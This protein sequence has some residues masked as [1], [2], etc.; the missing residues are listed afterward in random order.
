MSFW[1]E[2]FNYKD[3]NNTDLDFKKNLKEELNEF[4]ERSFL[5]IYESLQKENPVKPFNYKLSIDFKR[6][7][8]DKYYSSEETINFSDDY[9][10]ITIS[11]DE[12]EDHNYGVFNS[13]MRNFLFSLKVIAEKITV[14]TQEDFSLSLDISVA[15]FINT[16]N[17]LKEKYNVSNNDV[18]FEK[19]P[20]EKMFNL[21]FN[22]FHI[23]RVN[24]FCNLVSKYGEDVYIFINKD[25]EGNIAEAEIMPQQFEEEIKN[26]FSFKN[27][28]LMSHFISSTTE[29]VSE[30]E[31]NRLCKDDPMINTHYYNSINGAKSEF[32]KNQI[33]K[34]LEITCQKEPL[35]QRRL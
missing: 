35:T 27:L 15:D 20:S 7:F 3:Y 30:E 13:K 26:E 22:K 21:F 14:L 11:K 18:Y 8:S 34:N 5:E 19:S 31:L 32:Q 29:Y 2:D 28:F 9:T 17:K 23:N 16:C 6:L 10:N 1:S 24:C 25:K 33:L 12:E 4:I